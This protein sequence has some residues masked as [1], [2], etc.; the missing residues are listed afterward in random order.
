MP[1]GS[2]IRY[3]CHS[4]V[5]T[6]IRSYNIIVRA[7]KGEIHDSIHMINECAELSLKYGLYT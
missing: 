6:Y 7:T 1:F 4:S 2:C 3:K 5:D